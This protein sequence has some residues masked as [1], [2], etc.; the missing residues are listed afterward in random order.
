MSIIHLRQIADRLNSDFAPHI[1]LVDTGGITANSGH[2]ALSR[3]LAAFALSCLAEIEPKKAASA[4]TDGFQDNGIDAI[5]YDRAEKTLYLVQSKWNESDGASIG[6]GDVQLFIQGVKDLLA[7]KK[8]RFNKR[9]QERWKV[10]DLAI[11]ELR[12][13]EL[14]VAYSGSGSFGV[15]P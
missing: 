11:G 14:V 10:I 9:I 2:V 8:D 15:E 1:D 6:R 3:S 5:W 7:S 13:L 4:V 12:R